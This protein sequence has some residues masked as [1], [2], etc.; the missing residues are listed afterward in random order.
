MRISWSAPGPDLKPS[1]A[2]LDEM[3]MRPTPE[4]LLDLREYP[5]LLVDDEP[6]NLRMFE[7]GLGREF[8]VLTA[9]SGEEALRVVSERPIA[10][11]LS[12]QRMRGMTGVE[13]LSRIRTLDPKT[14]RI[15]VTAYGDAETLGDAIND[16]SVYRYVPKPWTPSEL[17][18]AVRRAI[19]VYALD[20]EKDELVKELSLLN[21]VSKVISQELELDALLDLLLD[22]VTHELGFDAAT[23]L[24][25]D[26]GAERLVCARTTADV[27]KPDSLS[28][29]AREAPELFRRLRAG[30]ARALARTPA[31]GEAISTF[32]EAT[33]AERMLVVPLLNKGGLLGAL[34]V[35]HRRSGGGFSA[36]DRTLLEGIASQAA[37]AVGNARLVEDLRRSRQQVLRAERLGTLG[38]L[39]AGLAHEIN[40]PLVSLHTFLSLAPSKRNDEDGEFWR[41]YHELACSELGRIRG[42]VATMARLGRG[43]A[44]PAP[45]VP[46]QVAELAGEA[47]T[48]L[49]REAQAGGV[50]LSVEAD[51]ETPKVQAVREQLQQ[52]VLNLA[53]NALHATPQG[54]RVTLRVRPGAR[55]GACIE[56][57]DTGSGVPAE[58]LERIFDP[59]FTTKDPDQGTGLGLMISHGIVADH[60]GT[61]EVESSEGWG[62]T[63]RV[64]LPPDRPTRG[65]S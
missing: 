65:A 28:I 7:R 57:V 41:D 50:E 11:V 61:I 17:H 6:E 42:L 24:L 35:D 40:N 22:T 37:I 56:V 4:H 43:A 48:L 58:D 60:G 18:L 47:A 29:P 1:P 49:S 36:G 14:I 32:L 15:L 34:A 21:W 59:F 53:L 51:P 45:R 10:V 63:F 38:T 5:V 54:G 39:A 26:E 44:E 52:V 25:A 23:L 8:A 55:G 13:L 12:D 27:P 2:A 62:T 16:G 30:E 31:M 20:R 19:E 9:S 3:L 33:G 46:C 64:H